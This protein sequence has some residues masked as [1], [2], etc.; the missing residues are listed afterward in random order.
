LLAALI[1]PTHGRVLLDGTDLSARSEAELAAIRCRHIGFVFQF[2]SLLPNLTAVDNIAIPALLGR[3]M[4]AE[5]AHRRAYE[6]LARVGLTDRTD[7]YPNVSPS[8]TSRDDVFERQ[9]NYYVYLKPFD[10]TDETV[11]KRMKVAGKPPV[12]IPMPPH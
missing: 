4:G 6:F 12:W 9:D 3:T 11:S 8:S 2:P 1:K 5:Q 10:V 7:A